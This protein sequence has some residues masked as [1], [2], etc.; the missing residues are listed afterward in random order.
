MVATFLSQHSVDG[1]EIL[2]LGCG[3]GKNANAFTQAGAR[4]VAVDC[5]NKAIGNGRVAFPT[6]RIEWHLADAQSFASSQLDSVYDVVIA[7]GLLH[8]MERESDATSLVHEI[9]RITK[10]GGTAIVVA[11]NDRSHD[12]SAHPGFAPLLLPHSW[13]LE[14]FDDWEIKTATDTVL[15]EAHPH[16][17]IHHHHSLTRMIV[18]K[19]E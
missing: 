4:V 3:E 11:F 2:D 14:A 16:N 7:Y 10:P 19:P 5:S 6:A 9:K 15:Y 8:C 1:L 13:F 18:R 12:L 17:E